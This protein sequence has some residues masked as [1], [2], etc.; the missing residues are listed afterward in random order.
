MWRLPNCENKK[1]YHI[2]NLLNDITHKM[3]E[4][5]TQSKAAKSVGA[6]HNHIK[7]FYV[8]FAKTRD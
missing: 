6:S 7:N 2:K 3:Y 1:I 8:F 5:C 4:Q